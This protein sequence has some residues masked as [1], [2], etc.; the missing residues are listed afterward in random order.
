MEIKLSGFK[1]A[2][3]AG[4]EHGAENRSGTQRRAFLRLQTRRNIIYEIRRDHRRETDFAL[5]IARDCDKYPCEPPILV[6][7]RPAGCPP[8]KRTAN[9]HDRVPDI[10]KRTITAHRNHL[11]ARRAVARSRE[12]FVAIQNQRRRPQHCWLDL[13]DGLIKMQQNPVLPK[14][15]A[16]DVTRRKSE[17]PRATMGD[18]DALLI[19]KQKMRPI[20][21]HIP[22][23]D[24]MPQA[25]RSR[26]RNAGPDQHGAALPGALDIEPRDEGVPAFRRAVG[27]RPCV[28]RARQRGSGAGDNGNCSATPKPRAFRRSDCVGM[29]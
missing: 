8:R 27:Q 23:A 25:M 1:I 15:P 4:R 9:R 14:R 11:L 24:R 26:H 12:S 10:S 18:P 2:A 29:G 20:N 22:P 5:I 16:L 7:H 17:R 6:E 28:K 3:N 19:A 21:A 13:G